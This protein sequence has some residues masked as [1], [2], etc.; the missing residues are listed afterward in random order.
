MGVLDLRNPGSNFPLPWSWFEANCSFSLTFL[1]SLLFWGQNGVFSKPVQFAILGADLQLKSRG[2]N[3][4]IGSFHL[5]ELDLIL[6]LGNEGLVHWAMKSFQN[7]LPRFPPH[8]LLSSP[9]PIA[10]LSKSVTVL[11]VSLYLLSSWGY[12]LY[13]LLSN[14]KRSLQMSKCWFSQGVLAL[15]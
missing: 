6:S 5:A 9:L 10:F 14:S 7:R 11:L 12:F 2:N 15:Q 4:W 1:T 13:V 8:I 3:I